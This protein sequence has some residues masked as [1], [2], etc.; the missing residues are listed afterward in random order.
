M[1]W[2]GRG[3]ALCEGVEAEVAVG[4][5]LLCLHPPPPPSAP[6][7]PLLPQIQAKLA[8]QV[9]QQFEQPPEGGAGAGAGSL[10][11]LSTRFEQVKVRARSARAAAGG[12]AEGVGRRGWGGGG[13][14]HWLEDGR[15]L[16]L[17][18]QHVL[19]AARS[20]LCRCLSPVVNGGQAGIKRVSPS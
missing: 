6:P 8:D 9:I 14:L 5:C 15:G 18:G 12:V 1:G 19:H 16:V 3:R 4:L 13:G 10:G 17:R 11:D 2:G 7:P 20:A